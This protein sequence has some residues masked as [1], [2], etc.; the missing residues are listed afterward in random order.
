MAARASPLLAALPH[1][2]RA[3]DTAAGVKFAS[4]GS[5]LVAVLVP[6]SMYRWW[7]SS[8]RP[9]LNPVLCAHVA[10][11]PGVG[12]AASATAAFGAEGQGERGQHEQR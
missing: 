12:L 7:M 1:H 5:C 8:R 2:A 11:V 6:C 4:L 10:L 3:A 9:S